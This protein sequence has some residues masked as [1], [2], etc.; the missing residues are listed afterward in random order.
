LRESVAGA[1]T[2]KGNYPTG[3]EKNLTAD[4]AD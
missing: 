1:F 4:C 3:E 2:H